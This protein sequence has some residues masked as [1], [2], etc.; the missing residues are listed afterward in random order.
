MNNTIQIKKMA[1]IAAIAAAA[2]LT[3]YFAGYLVGA[4]YQVNAGVSMQV[5]W[6]LAALATFSPLMI[7]G[8]IT[9]AIASKRPGFQTFASWA[10]LTVATL[11]IGSVLVATQ[12]PETIIALAL[13]HVVAG[14][15]WFLASKK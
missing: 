11:S 4:N 12:D 7:A 13:M 3:I 1:A 14:A 10:G 6:F 15:A 5:P 8:V 2:N 9:K